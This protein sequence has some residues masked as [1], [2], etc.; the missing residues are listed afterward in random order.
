MAVKIN[1]GGQA[2]LEMVRLIM[3]IYLYGE[4]ERPE[5]L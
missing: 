1:A 4:E 3:N 5:Y 2:N